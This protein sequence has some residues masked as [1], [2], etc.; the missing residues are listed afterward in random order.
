MT[1]HE[2]AKR[3]LEGEDLPVTIDGYEGGVDDVHTINSPKPLH[4]NVNTKEYYGAHEY[5]NESEGSVCL[6]SQQLLSE[7]A[8]IP[9]DR[10]IHLSKESK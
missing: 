8:G 4:R 3:L 6:F 10:A 1:A 9:T 2:L 5:H 7:C